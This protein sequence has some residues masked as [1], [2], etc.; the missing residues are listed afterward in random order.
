MKKIIL[1]L[2]SSLFLLV[3]CDLEESKDNTPTSNEPYAGVWLDEFGTTTYTLTD[4]TVL[5]S[6]PS[7]DLYMKGTISKMSETSFKETFTHM[8]NDNKNWI[9][10][11]P[12]TTLMPLITIWTWTIT[13]NTLTVTDAAD[14]NI[15]NIY[16]KK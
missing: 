11:D 9:Q 12:S 10:V 8:S 2:L 15:V 4:S 6:S 5:K 7:N 16:T 3:S 14:S 13:N 1:V